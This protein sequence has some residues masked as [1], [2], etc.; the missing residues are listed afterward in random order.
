MSIIAPVCNTIYCRLVLGMPAFGTLRSLIATMVPAALLSVLIGLILSVFV[1]P[2]VSRWLSRFQVKV[3]TIINAS[4][5]SA[6]FSLLG[7][8]YVRGSITILG[9]TITHYVL[10]PALI[11]GIGTFLHVI[12]RPRRGTLAPLHDG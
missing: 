1:P 3:P 10:A 6:Y 7:F 8:G 11:A 2:R 5:F 9:Y 4:L 12:V